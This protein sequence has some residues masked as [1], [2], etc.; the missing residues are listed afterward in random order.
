MGRSLPSNRLGS[1]GRLSTIEYARLLVAFLDLF[2]VLRV[3]SLFA[4]TELDKDPF[5]GQPWALGIR[6][7]RLPWRRMAGLLYAE[8]LAHD[9]VG[10]PLTVPRTLWGNGPAS[11]AEPPQGS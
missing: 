8:F 7:R 4:P 11:A 3:C 5:T 10:R 6:P 2:I 1:I 9:R